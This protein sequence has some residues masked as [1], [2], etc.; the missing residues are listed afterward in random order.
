MCKLH[1]PIYLIIECYT[2]VAYCR[3]T[4]Y[5]EALATVRRLNETEKHTVTVFR[6]V[7]IKQE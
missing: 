1:K 2:G 5:A 7:T 3:E 4:D 6:N